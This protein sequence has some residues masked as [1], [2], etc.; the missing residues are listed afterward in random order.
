MKKILLFLSFSLIT[1]NLLANGVP[2]I[3]SSP[4]NNIITC[5]NTITLSAIPNPTFYYSNHT[6][7]W[8]AL[9]YT[10]YRVGYGQVG[11]GQDFTTSTPGEYYVRV[12]YRYYFPGGGYWGGPHVDYVYRN[13]PTITVTAVCGAGSLRYDGTNDH[14]NLLN[15]VIPTGAN[16]EWSISAWV[17][18][19][20]AGTNNGIVHAVMGQYDNS[21]G[22]GNLYLF[23]FNGNWWFRH[24]HSSGDVIGDLGSVTP[25]VWTNLAVT[26][27]GT[28]VRCYKNGNLVDTQGAL[29]GAVR[30]TMTRVGRRG[31][32]SN[33]SFDGRIDEIRIWDR[34]LCASEL[35]ATMNCELSGTEPNL[36]A[37]YNCNQGNLAVP[38]PTE[39]TMNDATGNH[40]GTLMLFGLTGGNS[41]WQ[42]QCQNV[43]GTCSGTLNPDWY[44]D[45]DADGYYVGSPV[46]QCL[47][48]G[49]GWT[50]FVLG[51][52]DCDDSDPNINPD[53]PEIC[54]NADDEDC[55]GNADSCG[56][57]EW[58]GNVNSSW[59]NGGNWSSGSMPTLADDVVIP[60]AP[61]GGNMPVV[62]TNAEANDLTV[63]TGATITLPAGVTNLT[64][65]GV[66][67]NNGTITLE[68]A[69]SLV[70]TTGSTLTGSGTFHVHRQ[71]HSN[72]QFNF[73]SS[74]M[75]NHGPLGTAYSYN[76]HTSTQD[77][78]DDSPSDPGWNPHGGTMTPGVGF[79]GDS[80]GMAHF[81][82][83]VNNGDINIPLVYYPFNPFYD[84]S[85]G[86]GTPF[87]LVGNPYPCAISAAQFLLDNSD[88]F[89]TIYFWNDDGTGGSDYTRHDFSLWNHTG[90]LNGGGAA[91]PS[92][93]GS[94]VPPN[95]SIA[96]CQGFYVRT[97]GNGGI[98]NFNNGQRVTGP[99]NQFLRTNSENSRLWFSVENE[100]VYSQI[101]IGA[102]EEATDQEDQMYDA[103]K[104]R[105]GNSIDLSAVA[106]DTEHAIMAFPPPTGNKTIPLR[107]STEESGTHIFKAQTIENFEEF[108]L[109][110]DDALTGDSYQIVEGVGIPVQLQSGEHLN[111]FYLN[112]VR[113]SF[114]GIEDKE[115]GELN[116]YAYNGYL[117]VGC[118]GCAPN[119]T[120]ELL[121]ISGRVVLSEA[122][123]QFDGGMATL[124]MHGLSTGV[125]VV[126]VTTDNQV[127]SQKILNQ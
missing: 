100:H 16:D 24:F 110:F 51:S 71:G 42:I 114:T 81:T 89:S 123:P 40:P 28:N 91:S 25:D 31:T 64:V 118:T 116:A 72:Q 33:T 68:N 121:D 7:Q 76:S 102:F 67:A 55:D 61:V 22:E 112:L 52:G 80:W 39:T 113:T 69:A 126:R 62:D 103:V 21:P 60:T 63:E 11:Q 5:G 82:G 59:F 44:L 36:L 125:Y 47:S 58:T 8:W 17:M 98:A 78:S 37:Y 3:S 87:N 54:G 56:A 101:L 115:E 12:R 107:V 120:I 65:A 74:P 96:S 2:S 122:N 9:R 85:S 19:D 124:D 88:L 20:A 48:P 111:R 106:Y 119:A 93:Q 14:V 26:Y 90:G 32:S 46:N 49:P 84:A 86:A 109:Y 50:T 35:Q 66:L 10:W 13:S 27:D 108:A 94:G 77:E 127:L 34:S 30:N 83:T 4:S 104:L 99:N 57:H 43:A 29:N 41:N 70:Q 75:T 15:P 23:E 45:A 117:H 95:G 105:S 6:H 18:P 92:G 97:T 38:N 79:A 53:S 73:W 1:A